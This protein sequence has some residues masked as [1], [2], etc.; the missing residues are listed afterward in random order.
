MKKQEY[1]E[2]SISIGNHEETLFPSP[3]QINPKPSE[4]TDEI[5]REKKGLLEVCSE[6]RSAGL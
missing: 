5:F 2:E 6:E 1:Q 3:D 4:T